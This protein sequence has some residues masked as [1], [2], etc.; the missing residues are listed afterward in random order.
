MPLIERRLNRGLC[1][2][3]GNDLLQTDSMSEMGSHL[4]EKVKSSTRRILFF[5]AK[6]V[7]GAIVGLTLALIFQELIGF[8]VI[9]LVLIIVV[10]TLALLRIMKPWNWGRLLVFD[11]ICFLVALLLKMYI[12]LAPGA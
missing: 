6:L 2:Y 7:S 1:L 3:S 5:L 9:S 11:L 12:S 4:Q 10:V 8:G